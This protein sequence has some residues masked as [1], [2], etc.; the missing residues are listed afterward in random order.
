[1]DRRGEYQQDLAH[2]E[3]LIVQEVLANQIARQDAR[4]EALYLEINGKHGLK[5]HQTIFQ[6]QMASMICVGKWILGVVASLL[7]L[8]IAAHFTQQA[9]TRDAL[10][11]LGTPAVQA[12]K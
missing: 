7:V 9:A 12:P 11:R 2:K 8:L 1:M 3:T 4:I 5:E 6:Q 10:L